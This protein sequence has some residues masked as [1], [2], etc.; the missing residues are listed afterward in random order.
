MLPFSSQIDKT[1][2]LANDGELKL[3]EF[4]KLLRDRAQTQRNPIDLLVMS[5]CETAVGDN[6]A[7]LGLAGVAVKA[8]AQSTLASL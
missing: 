2:L 1:F 5:A 8:G 3:V 7:T 4:D 6:R